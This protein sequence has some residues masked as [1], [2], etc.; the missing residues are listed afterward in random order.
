M[1]QK[2]LFF[3]NL[4]FHLGERDMF[5]LNQVYLISEGPLSF[6]YPFNSH[7]KDKI[8]ELL[9][10]IRNEGHILFIKKGIYKWK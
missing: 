6:H 7:I 2:Q 4:K 5:T 3:S 9:Q 1:T 10:V 8:R